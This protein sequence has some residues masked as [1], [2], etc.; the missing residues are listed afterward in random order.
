MPSDTAM[1][2]VTDQPCLPSAQRLQR[3]SHV[4]VGGGVD[5]SRIVL[6]PWRAR[7]DG[8]RRDRAIPPLN[9][10]QPAAEPFVEKPVN[11]GRILA[12]ARISFAP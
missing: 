4:P 7:D 10:T 1:S 8:S 2:G 11:V 6:L 3:K 12:L 5:R 9:L